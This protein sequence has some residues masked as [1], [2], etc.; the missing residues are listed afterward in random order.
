MDINQI[1]RA[2]ETVLYKSKPSTKKCLTSKLKSNLMYILMWVLMNG[3]FVYLL[4]LQDIAKKYWFVGIPILCFDLLG[5]LALYTAISKEA[6]R[7]SDLE[8]VLTNK[9][10]YYI[11]NSSFKQIKRIYFNDITRFE[12]DSSN[13]NVFYVCTKDDALKFEYLSNEDA[14]YS[15]LAKK[16]NSR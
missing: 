6:N 4:L 9:A 2:D 15:E 5:L 8:Y 14:F 11:N 7:I 10:V 3:F 13:A 1:V 16:V 12:K